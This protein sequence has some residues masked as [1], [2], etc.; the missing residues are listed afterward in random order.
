MKFLSVLDVKY[1]MML[2]PFLG[3]ISD[4]FA[5]IKSGTII[6]GLH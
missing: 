5:S 1:W 2:L 3:H 4:T 6:T